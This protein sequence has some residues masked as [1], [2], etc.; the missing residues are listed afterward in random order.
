M[1]YSFAYPYVSYVSQ[2]HNIA[3]LI[4]PYSRP[5]PSGQ[6]MFIVHLRAAAHSHVRWMAR[7]AVSRSTRIGSRSCVHDPVGYA[8]VFGQYACCTARQLSRFIGET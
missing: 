5:H 6:G 4:D 2:L 7:H 8:V 1:V 3:A